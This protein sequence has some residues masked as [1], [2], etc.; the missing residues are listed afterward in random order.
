MSRLWPIGVPV[1]AMHRDEAA[2]P[3]ACTTLA[4]VGPSPS[5]EA[6]VEAALEVIAGGEDAV[7]AWA[8]LDAERARDEAR[9]APDGPLRGVTL[10]VKDIFDT[11]DQPSEY[12]SAIY[13]GH[14]PRADAAVVAL[15]RAAGAIVLGK[16]VT[17]E[18]AWFTPG[19]TTNPHRRTHT[20]GGSSSGSAAA[21][22]AGMVDLALGTQTAGSVIRPAS[23]CGV[24]GL[25]PTY[26]LLPTAGVKQAAPSLDTVGLLARDL[27]LLELALAV[28]TGTHEAGDDPEPACILVRTD[29]WDG[30]DDDCKAVVESAAESLGA[31]ARELPGSLVGLGGELPVVQSYEGARSLAWERTVHP[32]LLSSQLRDIL[33]SGAQVE[34]GRYASVM[35]RVIRGRT[36]DGLDALFGAADVIVT[37]AAVGEAPEGLSSTGDPRFNRLWT[38]L[39]C[40]ALTVPGARGASGLPIGVQLV[41]RPYREAL[42]LRAG[43]RLCCELR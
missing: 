20:P 19:P 22:A 16:T 28:L 15:L 36:S 29:V 18:L 14:R 17:A 41:A 2:Q 6:A 9:H 1:A 30:A 10:G 34:L 26:G 21:V 12:G 40:P 27:V 8:H 3:A 43:R 5:P 24:L 39:G 38:M 32:E 33:D 11:A 31:T 35:A 13:A 4:E 7:R 37:P 42:L 23:F 25:K